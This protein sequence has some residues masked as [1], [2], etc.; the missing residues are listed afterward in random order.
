M[1]QRQEKAAER[2]DAEERC[3]L[4]VPVWAQGEESCDCHPDP[5]RVGDG[6]R[7]AEKEL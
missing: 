1:R 2:A 3:V 6:W 5:G 7:A 4:G